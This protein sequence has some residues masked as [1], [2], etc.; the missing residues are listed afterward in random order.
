V[1]TTALATYA[2]NHTYNNTASF[3]H[4]SSLIPHNF[5]YIKYTRSSHSQAVRRLR[6]RSYSYTYDLKPKPLILHNAK[7]RSYLILLAIYKSQLIFH[8][9]CVTRKYPPDG[10]IQVTHSFSMLCKRNL[11]Y[12]SCLPLEHKFQIQYIPVEIYII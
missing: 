10:H 3:T 5:S 8:T 1:L 6:E 9:S 11:A 4:N 12:S 7:Y 2:S